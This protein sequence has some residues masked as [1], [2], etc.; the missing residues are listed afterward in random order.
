[1]HADELNR[2]LIQVVFLEDDE[3]RRNV[4]EQ[5]LSNRGFEGCH[6]GPALLSVLSAYIENSKSRGPDLL[7]YGLHPE[8]EES[9]QNLDRVC[10]A[11]SGPTLVLSDAFDEQTRQRVAETVTE[12]ERSRVPPFAEPK[13]RLARERQLSNVESAHLDATVVQEGVEHQAARAS[14]LVLEDNLGFQRARR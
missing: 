8:Q 10:N 3:P 9:W 2:A 7:I 5:A 14:M 11:F 12:I 1:V 4:I 6:S 13:P